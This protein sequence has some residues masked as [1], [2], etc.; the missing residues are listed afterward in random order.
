MA[1]SESKGGGKKP[2]GGMA[3]DAAHIKLPQKPKITTA[4]TTT[5][6]SKPAKK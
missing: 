5:S 6:T 2:H 1:E 4:A 3:Q